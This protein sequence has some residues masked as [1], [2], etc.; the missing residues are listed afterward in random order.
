MSERR[1]IGKIVSDLLGFMAERIVAIVFIGMCYAAVI[2]KAYEDRTD[3]TW[4]LNRAIVLAIIP[5]AITSLVWKSFTGRHDEL[6]AT[7]RRHEQELE[8][9]RRERDES[10]SD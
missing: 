9:L 2:A 10:E 5:T 4:T 6:K 8:E 7:I 3:M 1:T